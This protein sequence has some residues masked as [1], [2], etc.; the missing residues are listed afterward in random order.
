MAS[1]R[2]SG[3]CGAPPEISSSLLFSK[4]SKSTSRPPVSGGCVPTSVTD[5]EQSRS[6][7]LKPSVSRFCSSSKSDSG[8]GLGGSSDFSGAGSG[9]SCE[10]CSYSSM[11]VSEM[12][13]VD[14]S[15]MCSMGSSGFAGATSGSS[16]WYCSAPFVSSGVDS[17]S[18][19]PSSAG[20]GSTGDGS[21]LSCGFCSPTGSCSS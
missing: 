4:L 5:V 14:S 19:L 3:C 6:G 16:C 1:C 8:A 9:C 13:D 12:G 21:A 7:G 20:A 10:F 17:T 18:S 15:G 2:S 11:G